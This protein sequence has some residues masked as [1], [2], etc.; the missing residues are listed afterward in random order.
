MAEDRTAA[1]ALAIERYVDGL[2]TELALLG[3]AESGDLAEEVRDMLLDAV[4]QDPERAFAEM[5][6]LGEPSR[7]AATLLAERG[8]APAGGIPSA[9]WWRMG[10]AA[11]I[12]IV[13]GLAAPV[14][15]VAAFY[16][17]AWSALVG[18][19]ASTVPIGSRIGI[20]VLFAALFALA[21]WLAW[22]WWAPWRNGG[23]SSSP[24]MM[25]A[26]I[27]VARLGGSRAVVL[28]SD[29][30]AAGLET[31]KLTAMSVG[32]AIA[33]VVLAVL[34]LVAVSTVSIGSPGPSE[35]SIVDRLAG[36]ASAQQ[37]QVTSTVGELYAAAAVRVPQAPQWPPM[38]EGRFATDLQK[39]LSAR[40]AGASSPA[41][42]YEIISVTNPSL[43]IWHVALYETSPRG[44]RRRVTLTYNLRVDWLPDGSPQSTF[45]L[46]GYAPAL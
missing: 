2:R 25:L 29:L 34:M 44:G 4:R 9:S 36:S 42:G 7:L 14:A 3:A 30:V 22:R 38:A 39:T 24:G 45:V 41:N 1:A 11:T 26:K 17:A 23:R 46:T 21:V 27:A 43:G 10:I 6:R 13:V 28:R 15:V 40:Y 20:S 37:E 8:I 31:P 18:P 16:G 33:S 12:D 35:A 5:E 19:W 32:T